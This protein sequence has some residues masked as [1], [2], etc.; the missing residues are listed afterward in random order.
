M[1]LGSVLL[2][3]IFALGTPC[4]ALAIVDLDMGI[5]GSR[6]SLCPVDDVVVVPN[7]TYCDGRQADLL[8]GWFQCCHF[9][10]NGNCLGILTVGSIPENVF[11]RRA[12]KHAP[13]RAAR[14]QVEMLRLHGF[15]RDLG[16]L[17]EGT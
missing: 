16:N 14:L 17:A 4:K 3:P 5:H 2:I 15:R 10:T 9:S 1:L 6:G 12:S 7:S 8:L 13:V 11:G